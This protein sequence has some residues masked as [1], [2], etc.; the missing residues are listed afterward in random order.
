MWQHQEITDRWKDSKCKSLQNQPTAL[1]FLNE[2]N[3]HIKNTSLPTGANPAP[4]TTWVYFSESPFLYTAY[5][6]LQSFKKFTYQQ[7]QKC[8]QYFND[9]SAQA[10]T[11]LCSSLTQVEDRHVTTG[12]CSLV[13]DAAVAQQIP[14][15]LPHCVSRVLMS[16][17][18]RI[19][20][21]GVSLCYIQCHL[22][23]P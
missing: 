7:I 15:A 4:L 8:H 13:A 1:A 12:P 11:R 6:K 3:K 18:H 19:N 23:N 9:S 21:F 22:P 20:P 17:L 2:H 16:S 10:L 14:T 5:M